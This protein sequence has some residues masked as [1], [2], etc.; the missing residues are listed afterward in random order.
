[1]PFFKRS[2]KTTERI[3]SCRGRITEINA[4]MKTIEGKI[5]HCSYEGF[6]AK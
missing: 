4:E 6:K 5:E 1:M 2:E 3:E